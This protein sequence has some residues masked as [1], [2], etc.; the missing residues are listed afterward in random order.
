MAN[1]SLLI[2]FAIST[3]SFILTF[4]LKFCSQNANALRILLQCE[5]AWPDPLLISGQPSI[6]AG[7]CRWQCYQS[8][9]L[10]RKYKQ[11]KKKKKDKKSGQSCHKPPLNTNE[12]KER[13][14]YSFTCVFYF[15]LPGNISL[16]ETLTWLVTLLHILCCGGHRDLRY[17]QRRGRGSVL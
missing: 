3:L 6:E 15:S 13:I 16:G 14:D 4:S 9:A 11:L 12:N 7:K 10:R 1:M 8:S 17:L 5:E 2:F